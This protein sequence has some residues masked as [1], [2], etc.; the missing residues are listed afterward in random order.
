ME[1][2]N[3]RTERENPLEYNSHELSITG[4]FL[5]QLSAYRKR[6][7]W[8]AVLSNHFLLETERDFE[9]SIASEIQS[10]THRLC[11]SFTSACGRYAFWRL[12]NRQAPE[13][14]REFGKRICEGNSDF[15]EDPGVNVE[16]SYNDTLSQVLEDLRLQTRKN[17]GIREMLGQL[18]ALFKIRR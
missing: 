8:I 7:E 16:I 1:K 17:R 9:I 14:E 10:G 4:H 11:C 3:R 2:E 15:P 18:L 5:D 6:R 13:I 12:K